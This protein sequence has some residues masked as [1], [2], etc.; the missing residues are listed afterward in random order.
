MAG[1]AH[2][3]LA[4]R[5]DSVLGE[6]EGGSGART[7][8]TLGAGLNRERPSG[9]DPP[10]T[11]TWTSAPLAADLDMVGEIELVLDAASTAPDTA[12]IAVLQ[13][14]AADGTVANVTAG[15]LRAGLR[16][17]DE[18]RSR[19]GA[20]SL[21]CRGFVPVPIGETVRYRVP[22]VATARRFA[23]GHCLRLVIAS[24][25]QALDAP[26]IMSFRHASVGTSSL[27][28]ILSSSRL[29]VPVVG[30]PQ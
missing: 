16:E 5:S 27:N 28:T 3:A 17:I 30:E 1:T 29:L 18:A 4:L 8:M 20:P 13:D 21:P 19:I 14:V 9:T 26:A 24:D 15:Y 22:L 11:L 7:L 10:A 2:R 23:A 12:W 25:D 6:D